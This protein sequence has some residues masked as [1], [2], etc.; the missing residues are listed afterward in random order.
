MIETIVGALLPVVITIGLGYLA[1]RH[2][3]FGP[4]EVPIL[5]R[6]VLTYALPVA[7]FVGTVSRT[8][9][10]LLQDLPLLIVLT[11]AIVGLY[12]VVL[13]V[14]HRALRLSLGRSAL[15]ALAAS[16]PNAGF[17]GPSVLGSLY[18]A[19]SGL[20]VAIGNLVIVLTVVPL[21]V[22]LLSVEADERASSPDQPFAPTVAPSSSPG[23]ASRT[24]IGK[25]IG[26]A[27]A[28]P[29]VWLPLLGVILVLSGFSLPTLLINAL[30]L[31][32]QS[33][34]G[35]ALFSAGIILAVHN[36]SVT[37]SVVALA[38]VK[39]IAE[40]GLVWICLLA[41]GYRNPLLGEAV[42]TTALPMLVTAVILAVQYQ[43]AEAEVA[44]TLFIGMGSSLV[45]VAGFIA[46]TGA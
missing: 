30:T 25:R 7:L 42:V 19:A 39:N 29:I 8:R 6:M 23:A 26:G 35:V 12:V 36:V 46:L 43:V 16:A 38:A 27:L 14:C 45:T 17:V 5:I 28:Q 34:S 21:T 3:D 33:A 1:A 13:L 44:S 2:H 22:I 37:A 40:P 31:L 32:G 10:A 15:A 20:P 4:R 41:L 11:A 24:T 9:A 18:G